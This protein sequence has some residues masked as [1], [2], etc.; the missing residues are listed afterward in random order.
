MSRVGR[1]V[2]GMKWYSLRDKDGNLPKGVSE[3]PA[4][5]FD[6]DFYRAFVKG[7][8]VE[9]VDRL[10]T[11]L[12]NLPRVGMKG[13]SAYREALAKLDGLKTVTPKVATSK[14]PKKAV[15]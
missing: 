10:L 2:R 3:D 15:K 8:K 1:L 14:T 6:V 9:Q 4:K 11:R 12:R 5:M 7:K 13:K